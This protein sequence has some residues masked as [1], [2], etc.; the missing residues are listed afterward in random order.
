MPLPKSTADLNVKDQLIVK[1]KMALIKYLVISMI[2]QSSSPFLNLRSSAML[3]IACASCK[4]D[5]M[6]SFTIT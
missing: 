1:N 5:F 4:P 2:Y 3:T 6:T